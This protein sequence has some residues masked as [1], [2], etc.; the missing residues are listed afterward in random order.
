M[1]VSRKEIT[2]I[3]SMALLLC[4]STGFAQGN[5]AIL[6]DS[7][8]QA[9]SNWK[10]GMGFG[11]NFVGGTNISLS[12]TL[13]YNVSEKV[14]FGVG[15]QYNYA[16]IKDLRKTTT[17]GG[18][19]TTFYSPTKKIITLLEFAELNVT[20]K[21]ETPTGEV[22]DSFWEAALFI[23]AGIN[24]TNKITIGAKYNMLYK[25]DESVY[26][27]PVIPFVNISF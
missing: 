15:L 25:E 20:S 27:T 5:T 8:S 24:V 2:F 14:T 17:I 6:P 3:I 12:P 23:G 18:N 7:T 9:Q 22:K 1:V 26:T 11:L 13:L 19:L 16:A 10:F 4:V 21:N